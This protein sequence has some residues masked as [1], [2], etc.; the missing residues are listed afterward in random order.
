MLQCKRSLSLPSIER[1][2]KNARLRQAEADAKIARHPDGEVVEDKVG[3]LLAVPVQYWLSVRDELAYQR[4]QAVAAGRDEVEG[5]RVGAR[6]GGQQ[7]SQ[8]DKAGE[9]P[10]AARR[11][12][13]IFRDRGL[14][15][16]QLAQPQL[17]PVLVRAH[18][19]DGGGDDGHPRVGVRVEAG[20]ECGDGLLE[21]LQRVGPRCD[22]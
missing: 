3:R 4:L 7:R 19:E 22:N 10:K 5:L 18:P 8:A 15:R 16:S 11:S 20:G 6:T 1:Q 2:E 9:I 13:A 17:A 21:D 12:Q 14:G